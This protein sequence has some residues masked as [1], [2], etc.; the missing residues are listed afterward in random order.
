M[1]ERFLTESKT[2]SVGG[3]IKGQQ[4]G[5]QLGGTRPILEVKDSQAHCFVAV[6]SLLGC[7]TSGGLAAGLFTPGCQDGSTWTKILEKKNMEKGTIWSLRAPARRD[8]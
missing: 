8:E 7:F 2:Q 3:R 5:E 4:K 1:N 6:K